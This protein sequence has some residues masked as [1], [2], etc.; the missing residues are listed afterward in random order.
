MKK[1]VIF[2]ATDSKFGDFTINH[3]LKSL[4]EN[5]NLSNTEIVI[6]DYGM[7]EE[8]IS[9]L[10]EQKVIIKKCVRNG[11]VT[12][13]RYKDMK[14]FLNETKNR[15]DQVLATDAGDIIFQS[16]ISE[17]F[18][19]DKTNFRVVC[20]TYN[21]FNFHN[22]YSKGMFIEEDIKNMKELLK[23]RKMINVG[24]IF[25]PVEEFLKICDKF[26]SI[27]IDKT[28][29]G[30]EQVALNYI[31]YR[32]G[33]FKEIEEKYNYVISTAANAFKI[34]DGKFYSN[35]EIIHIVHNTGWKSFLR[36]VKNFGYGKDFNKVKKGY[37]LALRTMAKTKKILKIPL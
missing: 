34:N 4:K 27:L 14:D 8:Q 35:G 24:I 15:Y 20:E 19:K 12:I 2:G 23:D 7:N 16:D 6:L 28:K 1:S 11:H 9:K 10:K 21:I 33:N 37:L 3:W 29:F 13:I 26:N 31:L 22:I 17:L 18:N 25:A 30:P 32:D 36:P 5:V